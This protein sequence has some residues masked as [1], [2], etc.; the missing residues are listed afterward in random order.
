MKLSSLSVPL[1]LLTY[2]ATAL[3]KGSFSSTAPSP[4]SMFDKKAGEV[5]R[6]VFSSSSLSPAPAA[7]QTATVRKVKRQLGSAGSTAKSLSDAGDPGNAVQGLMTKDLNLSFDVRSSLPIVSAS[8]SA[9]AIP[10]LSK[11]ILPSDFP[12]VACGRRQR[13]S[14]SRFQ[15]C[16]ASV[17][18]LAASR[19]RRRYRRQRG[20]RLTPPA[21]HPAFGRI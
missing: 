12:Y 2:G 20:P 9:S 1:L 3:P 4:T 7:R 19:P 6:H 8:A 15:V 18:W 13:D 21:L 10:L 5:L 11:Q 16:R 14:C 17:A